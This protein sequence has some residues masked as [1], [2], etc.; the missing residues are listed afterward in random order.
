M[1]ELRID[2]SQLEGLANRLGSI[3]GQR[4]GMSAAQA[5]NEVTTR[6]DEVARAGQIADIN[7]TPAYVRSKTDLTLATPGRTPRAEIV[8]RG[9][10]TILGR[11]APLRQ[12]RGSVDNPKGGKPRGAAVQIRRSRTEIQPTWFLMRLRQGVVSGPDTGVFVRDG[13]RLKHIYGPSP[14]SLFRFQRDTRADDLA[15]D[16]TRTA[17]QLL[18]DDITESL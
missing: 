6:F 14:Y 8:T 10:L 7:L 1:T 4:L 15:D 13:K 5:V 2:A 11:Y 3:S 12:L 17:L 18:G 16:L 9:D